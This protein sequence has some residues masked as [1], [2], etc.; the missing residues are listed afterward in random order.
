MSFCHWV[1]R[2]GL[3]SLLKSCAS[4]RLRSPQFFR[5]LLFVFLPLSFRF[6]L[7]PVRSGPVS[8]VVTYTFVTQRANIDKSVGTKT[9]EGSVRLCSVP[10]VHPVTCLPIRLPFGTP[11]SRSRYTRV[12][13]EIAP[14]EEEKPE[15]GWKVSFLSCLPVN[16]VRFT[17]TERSEIFGIDP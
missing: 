1:S 10:P 14:E 15:R 6:F 16:F 9:T 5:G 7:V 8:R 2:L 3:P 13:S 12:Y 17:R 11:P 4:V